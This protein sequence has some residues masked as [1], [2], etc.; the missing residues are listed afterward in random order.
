MAL[1]GAGL[2][3]LWSWPPLFVSFGLISV[4]LTSVTSISMTYVLDA[5]FPA[6]AEALLLVNALKNIIAF[7]LLY[8]LPPWVAKVGYKAVS[9]RNAWYRRG[10]Q[11]LIQM[12]V[13]FRRDGG[14]LL[15][16]HCAWL[17]I[18][19]IW[20]ANP[21]LYLEQMANHFVVTHCFRAFNAWYHLPG[22]LVES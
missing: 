21:P 14:Y 1:F 5:Y 22:I 8:G 16:N 9:S 19:G 4:T 7:G 13:G 6:A 20:E 17:C 15:R 18:D 12:A 10:T 11:L 3:D 2:E